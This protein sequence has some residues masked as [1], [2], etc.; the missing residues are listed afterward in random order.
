VKVTVSLEVPF[1]STIMLSQTTRSTRKRRCRA[2]FAWNFTSLSLVQKDL[3]QIMFQHILADDF[4]KAGPQLP[5]HLQIQAND[6][7]GLFTS[8]SFL[9][10]G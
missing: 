9:P 7:I 5:A 4:P 1:A 6:F 10:C 8:D 2:I 3:F